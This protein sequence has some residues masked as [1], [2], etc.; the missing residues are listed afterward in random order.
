MNR[1]TIYIE[2][3]G[4]SWEARFWQTDEQR[5]FRFRSHVEDVAIAQAVHATGYT[6]RDCT[7][8]WIS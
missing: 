1:I 6:R 3:S 4:G 8:V 5:Y 7:I 2:R